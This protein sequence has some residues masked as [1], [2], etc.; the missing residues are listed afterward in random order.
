VFSAEARFGCTAKLSETGAAGAGSASLSR[1]VL[2][3]VI[4]ATV[5]I[6]VLRG[7]S[8][9]CTAPF[10]GAGVTST[11]GAVATLAL[12]A[13]EPAAGTL[14]AATGWFTGAAEAVSGSVNQPLL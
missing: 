10:T 8:G 14:V 4:S 6:S 7:A 5:G 9:L 3:D 13:L 1:R 2:P 12:T 11:A